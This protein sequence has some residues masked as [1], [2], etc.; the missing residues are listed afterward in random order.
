MKNKTTQATK[1]RGRYGERRLAKKVH[2]VVVGKSKYAKLPSGRFVQIDVTHPPDVM[3]DMFAYE[4][5]WIKNPPKTL[6]KV[7]GQAVRNAPEGFV[8]VAVIGDR[9]HSEV[10]YILTEHDFIDLH[11]GQNSE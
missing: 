1:E 9:E 3:D 11:V 10:F 6:S 5:K 8:P 7:V 2:G 4:S